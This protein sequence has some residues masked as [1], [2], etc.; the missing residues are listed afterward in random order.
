MQRSRCGSHATNP[1]PTP[2]PNLTLTFLPLNLRP[3]PNPDPDQVRQSR[4]LLMEASLTTS[5]NVKAKNVK[6]TT[7]AFRLQSTPSE[8]LDGGGVSSA[9][10]LSAAS[11]ARN[12]AGMP[13]TSRPQA[14][15]GRLAEP[16]TSR[17]Q[18]GVTLD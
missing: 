17:P 14:K 12:L 16:R 13:Q 7:A 11:E 1:T 6:W 8:A 9:A 15:P 18:D 10:H 4:D 5:K 2:N 3:N